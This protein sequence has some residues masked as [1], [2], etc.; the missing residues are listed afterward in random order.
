MQDHHPQHMTGRSG[1]ADRHSNQSAEDP[2]SPGWKPRSRVPRLSPSPDTPRRRSV[3][4]DRSNTR[5]LISLAA[6]ELFLLVGMP[7]WWWLGWI[8]GWAAVSGIVI[9][10]VLLMVAAAIA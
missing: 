7:L 8:P 9:G 6:L 1:D 5:F 10:I 2:T 3:L 4:K